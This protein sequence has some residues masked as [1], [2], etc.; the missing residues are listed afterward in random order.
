MRTT[1]MYRN[2]MEDSQRKSYKP[3]TRRKVA[4][5]KASAGGNTPGNEEQAM[6]CRP[7][8][9]AAAAPLSISSLRW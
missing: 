4:K 9:A 5:V 3:D 7:I 2:N 8:G 6:N 1:Q